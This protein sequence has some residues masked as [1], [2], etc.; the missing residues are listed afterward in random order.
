ML[1]GALWLL[2]L[3]LPLLPP[4]VRGHRDARTS[5]QEADEQAPWPG[6]QRLKEQL[7]TAGLLS[8]RY[9]TLFSCAMWPD[10]CEDQETPAPPLGKS[11]SLPTP[12][13]PFS[14]TFHAPCRIP[15]I[16]RSD[17]GVRPP[18]PTSAHLRVLPLVQQEVWLLCSTPI[19]RIPLDTPVLACLIDGLGKVLRRHA[20]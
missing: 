9:W 5:G 20:W 16:P 17:Q 8:K 14:F 2:L 6:I 7:R 19:Y 10:H 11:A 18:H 3:V 4:G 13:S 12:C 1:R 15:S